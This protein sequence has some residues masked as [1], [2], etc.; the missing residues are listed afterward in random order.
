ME[1]RLAKKMKNILKSGY[2]IITN[3]NN[4]GGQEIDFLNFHLVGKIRFGRMIWLPK[5]SKKIF[6]KIIT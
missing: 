6:K 5:E 1:S 2:I 4:D 3:Y